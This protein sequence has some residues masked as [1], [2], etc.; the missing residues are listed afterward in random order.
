LTQQ[1]TA[2][3]TLVDTSSALDDALAVIERASRLGVDTEADSRHHFPEKVCLVQISAGDRVF[4]IDPLAPLEMTRLQGVLADPSV[5]KILHG[6]DFDLR[7]LNRDWGL[8]VRGVYDTN[9]AARFAGL[10][11]FGLAAL[12]EDLLGV[13]IPKDQ[14]LQR[15]D[16][17]RR[18]LSKDALAYAAG[19]VIYLGSVRDALDKRLRKLKRQ[20][21][22]AEEV[23]R[24]ED[25]RYVPPDPETA[26]LSVRGSSSLDGKALAVL[27]S[28]FEFRDAEARRMDRPTAFV[29]S[30]EAMVH[31]A[32]HPETE[33]DEVPGLGPTAVRRIGAGIRKALQAGVKAKPLPRLQPQYPFRPRPSNAQEKRLK[34]LK[35]WRVSEGEKR[36]MDPALLW[37]MR[38]LERLAREPES[39]KTELESPEIRD[40]QRS[41]C[42][43]ALAKQIGQ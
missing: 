8:E 37:P 18:P 26:F 31:M 14:R 30:A 3:H 20:R 13:V 1:A 25:I 19:D 32:K 28:L 23:V 15:S 16:W 29:I 9:V 33:L 7:G 4:I 36:E 39:W 17:S 24:F 5:E 40:W 43:K 27:R 12:I 21:W 6:A 42:A 11:R 41:E 35:A 22:V 10:E 34:S 38:S 2:A